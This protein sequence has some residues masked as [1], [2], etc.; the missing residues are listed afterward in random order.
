MKIDSY[1]HVKDGVNPYAV[2]KTVAR[3]I[4]VGLIL[5]SFGIENV[6]VAIPSTSKVI[7]TG[8]NAAGGNTTKLIIGDQG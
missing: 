4:A 7:V 3:A 5:D 6:E 1:L 2:S 8:K